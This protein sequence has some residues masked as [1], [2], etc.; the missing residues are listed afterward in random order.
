MV[1]PTYTLE[2]DT[3]GDGSWAASVGANV[4][5]DRLVKTDRGADGTALLLPPKAGAADVTLNNDAGHGAGAYSP[6]VLLAGRKMRLRAT[7]SAVTYNLWAGALQTPKQ[8]PSGP[9]PLVNVS[10]FGVLASLVKAKASTALYA[11][12]TVGVAI[13]YLLDAAGF[14]GTRSLDAG[15]TTLAWYWEDEANAL[16]AL[17]RLLYA[18]GPGARIYEDGDGALVFKSRHARVTDARSTTSQAAFT[19][20]T[21]PMISAP[22]E[23]DPGI[24]AVINDAKIEVVTREASALAAI[25]TLR[26]ALVLAAGEVRT[27]VVRASDGDPFTAA[28]DPVL[29]TDYTATAGSITA[30]L[31]RTS[32]GNAT[33][34]VTAGASGASIAAG[35]QVRAQ[36]VEVVARTTVKNTISAAASIAKYGTISWDQDQRG[37]IAAVDAQDAVNAIVA[38]HQAGIPRLVFSVRGDRDATALVQVLA[39]EIG[40]RVT[41]TH[42]GSGVAGDFF[43]E[44]VQHEISAPSRH[45]T[46]FTCSAVPTGTPAALDGATALDGGRVLWF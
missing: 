27:Y 12:V 11:N 43:V 37:E 26:T 19:L 4:H 31:S 40:D 33:L 22:F 3:A 39:R 44:R 15:N 8:A 25:W 16:D 17:R 34:T 42:A 29:T 13:G 28:L 20:L 2:I 18:E 9:V 41:V 1:K 30:T 36:A 10:G 35:L 32:G 7:Y 5:G 45:L 24:E 23:Y 6:G 14:T 46:T 38:H 21:A